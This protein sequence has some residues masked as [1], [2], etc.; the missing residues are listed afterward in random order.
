MIFS[1]IKK[2]DIGG[3]IS[4][5]PYGNYTLAPYI[6]VP[7]TEELLK[8]LKKEIKIL[9][10]TGDCI[11]GQ[12]GNVLDNIIDNWATRAKTELK[13]QRPARQKLIKNMVSS[14]IANKKNATVWLNNDCKRLEKINKKIAKYEAIEEKEYW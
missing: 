2:K 10:K 3:R 8:Y 5:V 6:I 4:R 9:K 13:K 14:R 12:N 1:H 11:D 7:N